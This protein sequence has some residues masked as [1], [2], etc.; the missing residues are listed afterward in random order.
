MADFD[1]CGILWGELKAGNITADEIPT[2]ID[3]EKQKLEQVFKK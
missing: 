1:K 2:A 3:A